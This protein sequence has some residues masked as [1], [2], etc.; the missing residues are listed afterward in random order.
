[1]IRL[2]LHDNVLAEVLIAVHSGG[3]ELNVGNAGDTLPV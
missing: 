3:E 2:A 1:M